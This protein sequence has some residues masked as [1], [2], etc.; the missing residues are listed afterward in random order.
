MKSYVIARDAKL[1]K[2][3]LDMSYHNKEETRSFV[4]RQ[5][6]RVFAR[7]SYRNTIDVGPGK[8]DINHTDITIT[9]LNGDGEETFKINDRHLE[10]GKKRYHLFLK[11]LK[12]AAPLDEF[13]P[14]SKELEETY[15]NTL[16]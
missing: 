14:I 8:S 12:R 9:C 7:I 6:G 4:L 2:M 15:L 13:A 3:E 16:Q 1:G 5:N 11:C 10:R